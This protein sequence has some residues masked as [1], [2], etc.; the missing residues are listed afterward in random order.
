MHGSWRRCTLCAAESDAVAWQL[1][2]GL[3]TCHACPPL[4]D[5][6]SS[7]MLTGFVAQGAEAQQLAAL[8]AMRRRDWTAAYQLQRS[9]AAS[10]PTALPA[11]QLQLQKSKLAALVQAA[12]TLQSPATEV[13]PTI[14]HCMS[15]DAVHSRP[16]VAGPA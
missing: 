6:L 16:A 7:A 12:E 13:L 15:S 9:L 5:L 10:A 2:S 8:H 1:G 4:L 14:R 11:A 3:L